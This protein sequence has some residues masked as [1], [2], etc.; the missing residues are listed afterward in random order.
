M[1]NKDK[2]LVTAATVREAIDKLTQSNLAH[3]STL[4]QG[5]RHVSAFVIPV[6]ERLLEAKESANE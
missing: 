2:S 1:K 4:N 3:N 6:L 5:A